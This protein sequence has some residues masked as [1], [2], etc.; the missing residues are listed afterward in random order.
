M[1]LSREYIESKIKWWETVRDVWDRCEVQKTD[2][3][4][5]AAYKLF[6]RAQ[7]TKNL[8]TDLRK[9]GFK[10]PYDLKISDLIT[11]NEIR[12]AEMMRVGRELFRANKDHESMR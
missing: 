3:V 10:L 2:T 11:Q 1:K 7:N 9:Y 5:E 8:R 12:D 6:I 4:V